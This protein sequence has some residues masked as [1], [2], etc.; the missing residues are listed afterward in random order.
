MKRKLPIYLHDHIRRSS[1]AMLFVWW[2]FL[3]AASSLLPPINAQ[4]T[5]EL[6]DLTPIPNPAKS[7]IDVD[8]IR[9]GNLV[10]ARHQFARC[11]ST[12]FL[13][14]A[15]RNTTIKTTGQLHPL[16][17]SN[18]DLADYPLTILA[19]EKA[20]T[21]TADERTN[22]KRYL[23]QGGFVLASAGCSSVQFD[24]SLRREV[25]E[26]FPDASLQPL[27][28]DHPVFHIITAI[29]KLKTKTGDARPLLGLWVNQ[30]LVL[31]YTPDGL[32]DTDNAPDCCCC[33]GN[34]ILNAQ[35]MM[36]NILAYV[37]SF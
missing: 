36:L 32:N 25:T 29:E 16:R 8:L 4:S 12:G 13:E 17:L 18:S 3:V 28:P 30:R 5:D 33:G 7:T 15:H 9:I 27:P 1:Y 31:I 23:E 14:L 34:E 26:L 11:F 19:G 37:L 24:R 2:L 35:A 6:P 22:L 10:Y 20:F 21:L